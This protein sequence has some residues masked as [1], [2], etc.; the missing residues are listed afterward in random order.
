MRV[1]DPERYMRTLGR[2]A[3]S[4]LKEGTLRKGKGDERQAEDIEVRKKIKQNED[5]K[6]ERREDIKKKADEAYNESRPP[7]E[8]CV[9]EGEHGHKQ[10]NMDLREVQNCERRVVQVLHGACQPQ[11]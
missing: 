9:P 7:S 4:T 8:R 2:L 1:D 3:E 11:S 5:R 10:G 6:E